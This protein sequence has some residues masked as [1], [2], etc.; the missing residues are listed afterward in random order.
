MLKYQIYVRDVNLNRVAQI[1]D[2]Q[3]LEMKP[4]FNAVGAFTLA[5]SMN[6]NAAFYITQPGAGII[7][8]RNGT[9]I[10]SGPVHQ[11]ERKWTAQSDDLTI[12][13]YDDNYILQTKLAYPVPG[14][15]PYTS[16]DYDVRTGPA[17]TI[18]K[19][20]INANIGSGASSN[21]KISITTDT[22]L[23]RGTS[24]TG[25]ARFDTLLALCGSLALQGGGLGFKVIQ[26]GNGLQFQVYQPTDKSQ[27]VVFSP[28]LGNLL[29]FDYTEQSPDA[30]YIIAAG[31]G[32]G[33]ARII[34][35]SGDSDSV[36][37]Y[38]RVEEFLNQN[39][40][41][42]TT[43]LSQAITEE[44]ANKSFSTSLTITPID[45]N[46][47]A[48]MQNYNLG[49][50][51]SVVLTQPGQT[52]DQINQNVMDVISDVVR[53]ITITVDEKGE[54]ITPL[55]GTA[56][57]ANKSTLRIFSSMKTMNRRLSKLERV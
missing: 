48:F 42:S 3:K 35:E 11:K 7:V 4:Q 19:Q 13:G 34:T 46:T 51:V 36:S 31:T 53:Q 32:E 37:M 23:G 41:S 57:A 50:I 38:G 43:E 15:P 14:G 22:D 10:F 2:Y 49:D 18:M 28:L 17:E 33:T 26:V 54:V 39:N 47:M 27:S 29:D 25:R 9:T 21:R 44:L 1:D 45:T 52:G 40:T 16:T 56:D 6:S 55:I 12:S 5:M 30:N 24:I 8:V 20:Y